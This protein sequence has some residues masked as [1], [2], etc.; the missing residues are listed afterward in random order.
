M[1]A[2]SDP[3]GSDWDPLADHSL[4]PALSAAVEHAS[5]PKPSKP[6]W[7]PA[8]GALKLQPDRWQY[9]GETPAGAMGEVDWVWQ[10][11]PPQRSDHPNHPSACAVAKQLGEQLD[12]CAAA[13]MIEY[14]PDGLDPSSFAHNI[15]PLGARVKKNGSVR[16]LVDPSLPGVNK[17]MADLPCPLTSAERIFGQLRPGVTLAKRDLEMG[18]YHCVMSETARKHMAFRHPVT[19]RLARWVV[20][21]QGTKQ[22]PAIFCAVSNAA[23]RIFDRLFAQLGL[24]VIVEVFVDDFILISFAGHEHMLLAFKAMDEEAALLG[25]VF[26]PEK[27]AGREGPLTRLEAL[28]LVMDSVDMTL[29]LPESKRTAYLAEISA[30]KAEFELKSTCPRKTLEKLVGKLVFACRVCTWGFLFIQEIMDSLFPVGA[31]LTPPPQVQLTAGIWFDLSFW[32]SALGPSYQTWMGISQPM[33]GRKEVAI[34]TSRF[35]VEIFTDASGSWGAGAVWNFEQLSQSWDRDT[36]KEHI[37]SLELEALYRALLHWKDRL[38]GQLVLARLDNIQAV[39]AVNKGASRKPALRQTLLNIA[40]LGLE[41]GFM[42]KARHVKGKLNP[43]DGP[44]RGAPGAAGFNY[45]FSDWELFNSPP[46]TIDCCAP[47]RDVSPVSSCSTVFSSTNPAHDNAEQLAGHRLWANI[48]FQLVGITLDAIARAWHLDSTTTATCVVPD[49]P[50][51]S[52]YRKYLRRRRPLFR[53]IHSYPAGAPIYSI[54]SSLGAPLPSPHPV[55]VIRM[56]P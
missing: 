16:M 41:A 2:A 29:S 4:Y 43:A 28:G 25:L 55:L 24:K 49:W 19:G 35:T 31:G 7:L 17:A 21:A 15:I 34:D 14:L 39:V 11:G 52:W 1:L 26:N 12:A 18:F 30:F 53:V 54:Y 48:P 38:R 46:A 45:V 47:A 23:A 44:S 40:L 3:S 56:G 13:G 10:L 27:D 50:T 32:E 36:S 42:V 5:D 9:W 6:N 37:G 20:L 8:P 51:A 33:I 22:S